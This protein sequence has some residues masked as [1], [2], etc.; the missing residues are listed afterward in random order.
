MTSTRTAHS[1]P[2]ALLAGAVLFL[3]AALL[4]FPVPAAESFNP[5][6]GKKVNEIEIG[7]LKKET[8]PNALSAS[9]LE[10]EPEDIGVAGAET[11]LRENNSA[12]QFLGDHY[13][14][15]ETVVGPDDDVVAGL[16]ELVGKG[17]RYVIVDAPADDLLAL[18]DAAKG[19]DVLLFNVRAPEI[20]L[21]QDNCRTNVLHVAPDRAMLADALAQYLIGHEWKDWLLV[22]GPTPEDKAYAS[23]IERAAD[24]F[25]GNIVDRRS[26]KDLPG[27]DRDEIGTIPG[28]SQGAGDD[29]ARY[30][31]IVVADEAQSWAPYA[32]YR[33]NALRPVVGTSGLMAESW[34]GAHSKWGARQLNSHFEEEHNRLMRPIDYHAYIAARTVGEGATRNRN[35]DFQTIHDFILSDKFQLNGFKGIR[36]T[37]RPWDGQFRQPILLVTDKVVVSV[38]PQPGFPHP[39]APD[40]LVDTLGIDQDESHCNI[41]DQAE[42]AKP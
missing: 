9:R 18:S 23:A 30:D 20:A 31:V 42:T 8:R 21:R 28:P 11:A 32:P 3:G 4:A 37:Y 14:V 38:S 2:L 19:K 6:A 17:V 5:A 40:V 25:G 10:K 12:G 29:V 36:H 16:N 24:R 7:Y 1:L 13:S 22:T 34:H 27:R 35:A 33:G 41:A 26:Y 39:S 15:T